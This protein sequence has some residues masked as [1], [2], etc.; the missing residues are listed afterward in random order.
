[1]TFVILLKVKDNF[2]CE[3]YT[4]LPGYDVRVN[5]NFLPGYGVRVNCTLLGYDVRVNCTFLRGYD[6][7]VNCTSL[8]VYTE[9][10]ERVNWLS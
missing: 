5:C 1:M 10:D 2:L 4:F 6:G 3:C 8:P 9:Y 7:R